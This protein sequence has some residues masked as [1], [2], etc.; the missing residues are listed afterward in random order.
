[1]PHAHASG[2]PPPC[3]LLS[4]RITPVDQDR[5][6][7][8]RSGAGAPELQRGTR[9]L[10]VGDAHHSSLRALNVWQHRD[11]E[12]S[13]TEKKSRPGGLSYGCAS[14]YEPLVLIS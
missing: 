10:P 7:L 4:E 12:V 13:P 14:R 3:V 9:C 11:Q 8:I 6:I 1:M 2:F 5:L